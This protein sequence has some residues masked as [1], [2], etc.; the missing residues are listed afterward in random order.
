MKYKIREI[1]G[2]VNSPTAVELTIFLTGPDWYKLAGSPVWHRLESYIDQ[3]EKGHTH[4]RHQEKILR[5]AFAL[6][7]NFSAI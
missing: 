1:Y 4:S 6:S 5:E 7:N 3:L 2:G